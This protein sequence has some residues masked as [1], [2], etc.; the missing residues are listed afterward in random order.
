V[1]KPRYVDLQD[2]RI[3]VPAS[4]TPWEEVTG[5]AS[6][7]VQVQEGLVYFNCEPCEWWSLRTG[8]LTG[9]GDGVTDR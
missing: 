7:V 6:P 5:N 8:W 2:N 1:L 4:P 9:R 3:E